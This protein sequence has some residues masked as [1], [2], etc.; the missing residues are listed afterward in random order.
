[1]GMLTSKEIEI[2]LVNNLEDRRWD[3]VQTYPLDE[4]NGRHV[5]KIIR[6][7]WKLKDENEELKKRIE[8][9]K[10]LGGVL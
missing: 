10:L 4:E 3:T 5:A 7:Y 6:E 8:A 1:M 2:A 9:N